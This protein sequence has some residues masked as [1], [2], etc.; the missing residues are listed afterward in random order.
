MNAG[1]KWMKFEKYEQNSFLLG[2]II[3]QIAKKLFIV[4]IDVFKLS[5]TSH[6]ATFLSPSSII[7]NKKI[8]YNVIVYKLEENHWIIN[9]Q[10]MLNIKLLITFNT[11]LDKPNLGNTISSN[12]PHNEK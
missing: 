2:I 4:A 5:A 8:F 10:F 7:C 1:L 12:F 9:V 6:S 3:K 11:Y